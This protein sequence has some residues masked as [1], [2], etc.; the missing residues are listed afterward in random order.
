MEDEGIEANALVPY[1]PTHGGDPVGKWTPY[2]G[3]VYR[4]DLM[5]IPTV[6]DPYARQGMK[7]ELMDG[8]EEDCARQRAQFYI[9]W[10]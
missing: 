7:S 6:G 5:S 9:R 2:S 4:H 1:L 3:I 10:L 8:M